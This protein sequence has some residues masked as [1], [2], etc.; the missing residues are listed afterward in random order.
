MPTLGLT[1]SNILRIGSYWQRVARLR[2]FLGDL[3][4]AGTAAPAALAAL[5]SPGAPKLA[6]DK[7]ES[8]R[9]TTRRRQ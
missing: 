5:G 7:G 8:E 4:F 2:G 1:L 6:A 3:L 9:N